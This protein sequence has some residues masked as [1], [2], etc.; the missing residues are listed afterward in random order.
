MLNNQFNL[1]NFKYEQLQIITKYIKNNYEVNIKY[2]LDLTLNN[3]YKLYYFIIVINNDAL[4]VHFV[5]YKVDYKNN[6]LIR[7]DD[8]KIIINENNNK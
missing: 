8:T 4:N 6:G 2:P 1:P 7:Y 3:K 5:Y